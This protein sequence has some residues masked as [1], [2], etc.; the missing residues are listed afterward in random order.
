MNQIK[1][2]SQNN[3]LKD[4]TRIDDMQAEF[5]WKIFSGFTTFGILEEI[6]KFMKK[7]TV[8]TWALQR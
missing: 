3:Y 2:Y 1:W 6:Q 5:E 4:L 7:C 8:W